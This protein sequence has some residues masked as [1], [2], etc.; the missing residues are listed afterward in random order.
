MPWLQKWIKNG[1][2]DA[3]V[4]PFHLREQMCGSQ[5]LVHCPVAIVFPGNI[6][7]F[8]GAMQDSCISSYNADTLRKGTCIE[9]KMNWIRQQYLKGAAV[10][11]ELKELLMQCKSVRCRKTLNQNGE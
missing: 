7:V 8:K 9:D 3:S 2:L 10:T 11:W 5:I 6:W 4:F 1:A